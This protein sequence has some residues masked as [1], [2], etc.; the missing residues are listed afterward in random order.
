MNAGFEKKADLQSQYI[1]GAQKKRLIET[2]LLS[3]HNIWPYVLDE[4][5]CRQYMYTNFLLRFKD[6]SFT[7]VA[8]VIIY[9]TA[10][11]RFDV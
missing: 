10:N 6:K 9:Y 2:V 5:K 7:M 8:C 3:I 1:L 11:P 4:N